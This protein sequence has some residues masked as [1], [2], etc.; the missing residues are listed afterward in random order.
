MRFAGEMR[1]ARHWLRA[2]P[3]RVLDSMQNYSNQ[4]A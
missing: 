4:D 3:E 2:D 1:F